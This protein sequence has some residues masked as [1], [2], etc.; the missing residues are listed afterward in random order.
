MSKAF[1][2]VWVDGLPIYQ[3]YERGIRGKRGGCC[4]TVT[5]GSC[6]ELKYMTG[7]QTG[8]R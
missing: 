8:M 2:R 6:A 4:L 3:L 1:D 5:K 7:S